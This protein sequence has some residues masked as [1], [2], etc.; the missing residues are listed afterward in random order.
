MPIKRAS[1]A[2]I[3]RMVKNE[4]AGDAVDPAPGRLLSGSSSP[5]VTLSIE[6]TPA[7]RPP[8]KSPE[9]KRGVMT[10]RMIRLAMAS[11]MTPSRP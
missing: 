10:S 9:R 4:L 5:R 8:A 3:M 11:G 7:S 2:V 1:M 6:S